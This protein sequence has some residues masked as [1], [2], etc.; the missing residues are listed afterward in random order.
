MASFDGFQCISALSTKDQKLFTRFASGAPAVVPHVIVHEAF[1]CQVDERPTLI[2]AQ[3]D[4]KTITYGDLDVQAN[5]LAN[6][7]I[8]SGLR[9]KQRVC[10]VVKRSFEM[11]A[12]ALAILKAGCQYVPLDGGVV[13]QEALHHTLRDTDAD[14]VLALPEF[15]SKIERCARQDVHIVCLGTN[16]DVAA[17]SHRPAVPISATD[18]AYAIYTSGEIKCKN[19][20]FETNPT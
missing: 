18:G 3:Y 19:P 11:L 4:G 15:K 9:P 20:R 6:Y 12:G 14:F 8:E 5:R 16:Q 7:L 17:A 2:A 13:S 10:L 1:E